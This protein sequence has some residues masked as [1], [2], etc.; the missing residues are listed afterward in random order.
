VVAPQCSCYGGNSYAGSE[1][2]PA[3][4][5]LPGELACFC[6]TARDFRRKSPPVYPQKVIAK[7]ANSRGI[8]RV[9]RN[10]AIRKR[11][12]GSRY[13]AVI[14]YRLKKFIILTSSLEP[15][16]PMWLFNH[17]RSLASRIR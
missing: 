1:E 4:R 12:N 9:P 3:S 10:T 15:C 13:A 7:G 8:V 17:T 16:L 14:F 5:R 6:G 2:L 11:Q